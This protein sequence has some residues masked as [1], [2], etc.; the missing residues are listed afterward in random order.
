VKTASTTRTKQA[1]GIAVFAALLAAPSAGYGEA[2]RLGETVGLFGGAVKG[3]ASA[4]D[5]RN[6]VF[7]VVSAY[8][9]VRG[10]FVTAS[11]ALLGSGAFSLREA[12]NGFFGH[13]P[14]VA[15]SP[16]A[17]NG[18]GAFLVTWHENDGPGGT[19]QVNARLVA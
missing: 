5:P 19:N 11:G 8:G 16:D 10:R 2:R 14:R 15:Y 13:A 9:E 1:C 18:Q 3:S 6:D 4:Y 7:L 12:G 17:N